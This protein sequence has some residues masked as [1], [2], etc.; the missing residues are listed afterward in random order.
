ML[1]LK[2]SKDKLIRRAVVGLLPSMAAFAPERFAQGVGLRSRGHPSCN[3]VMGSTSALSLHPHSHS[4]S[5]I[6]EQ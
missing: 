4:G 1:R 3:P 6:L 2:D 5:L